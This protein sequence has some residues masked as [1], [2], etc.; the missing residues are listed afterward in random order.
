MI[1]FLRNLFSAIFRTEDGDH[2]AKL[3]QRA[4]SRYWW[5]QQEGHSFVPGIYRSLTPSEQKILVD[6]YDDTDLKFPGGAGE[7]CVPALSLIQGLVH[8]NGI[9]SVVQCGHYHGYSTLLIGF[10]LKQI[11]CKRGLFSID[12]N[13][14]VTGYTREW[15]K[16]AGLDDQV[17]LVE[18]SSV[19]PSMPQQAKEYLSTGQIDLIYID[20]S[21]AYSHTLLELDFWFEEL[22]PGGFMLIHD[23]SMFAKQ[24]C[25]EERGGVHAALSDWKLGDRGTLLWI[26]KTAKE[27]FKERI[28]AYSDVCGMAIIHKNL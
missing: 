17:K 6:W 7:S 3:A 12:I 5:H 2:I 18:G 26:N 27:P 15:V 24:F 11:G 25:S 13:K 16:R 20:S 28:P 14:D 22:S 23:A 9:R 1:D 19:F 4:Q 10:F 21:H 8:G